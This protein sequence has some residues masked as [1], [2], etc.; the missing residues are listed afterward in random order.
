MLQCGSVGS[1]L[2]RMWLTRQ[3]HRLLA[4]GVSDISVQVM[5]YLD[6]FVIALA[7]MYL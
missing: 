7:L 6:A 1:W 4:N 2:D 5:S 3:H